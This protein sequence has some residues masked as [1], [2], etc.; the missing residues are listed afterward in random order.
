MIEFSGED[1]EKVI[2]FLITDMNPKS[3]AE[4][5]PGLPAHIL[6]MCIRHCDHVNDD[7]RMQS[8]LTNSINSIRKVVK[9]NSVSDNSYLINYRKKSSN[10]FIKRCFWCWI[11]ATMYML[12]QLD[13][14]LTPIT[15]WS[16][17]FNCCNP[18]CYDLPYNSCLQRK[19]FQKELFFYLLSFLLFFLRFARNYVT[20]ALSFNRRTVSSI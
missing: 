4:A 7:R 14:R 5:I 1:E 18:I 3:M 9:V 8:L 10:Y 12:N 16:L 6:F 13:G 15:S 19:K 20:C 2:K 17:A 11:C